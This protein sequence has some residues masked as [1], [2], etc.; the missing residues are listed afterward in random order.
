[1]HL[2][3]WL[4][5]WFGSSIGCAV[6]HLVCIFSMCCIHSTRFYGFQTENHFFIKMT[7]ETRR[8]KNPAQYQCSN[9]THQRHCYVSGDVCFLLHQKLALCV[10]KYFHFVDAIHYHFVTL[11]SKRVNA[12][13]LVFN[14]VQLCIWY[15]TAKIRPAIRQWN[16]NFFVS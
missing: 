12:M 5:A 8:E 2:N 3:A 11:F 16:C 6:E 7:R 4:W 14:L 15:L 10:L 1:M 13:L 9:S